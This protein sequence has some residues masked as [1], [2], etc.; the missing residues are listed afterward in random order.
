ML[1]LSDE[2]VDVMIHVS[3]IKLHIRVTQ[4]SVKVRCQ[5]I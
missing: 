2:H 5:I 4:T 1:N 3:T